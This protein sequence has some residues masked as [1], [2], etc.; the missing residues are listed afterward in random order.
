MLEEVLCMCVPFLISCV[1]VLSDDTSLLHTIS[2]DAPIGTGS[3][4]YR[5]LMVTPS[6]ISRRYTFH[7]DIQRATKWWPFAENWLHP[8]SVTR[9]QER[10]K[11]WTL[12]CLL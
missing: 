12:L 11:K 7:R 8:R 3:L 1:T 5:L 2:Q 6:P 9:V 4:V 10:I